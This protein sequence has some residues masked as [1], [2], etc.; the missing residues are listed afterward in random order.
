MKT[1]LKNH[2][3][4]TKQALQLLLRRLNDLAN[5]S[6]TDPI[7]RAEAAYFS[8]TANDKCRDLDLPLQETK[9]LAQRALNVCTTLQDDQLHDYC[10]CNFMTHL[11]FCRE[12]LQDDDVYKIV[13]NAI[14]SFKNYPESAQ[15]VPF[16][17]AKAVALRD[18]FNEN[19]PELV[20]QIVEDVDDLT[21][22]EK[23]RAI[24]QA[25]YAIDKFLKQ[26]SQ[27]FEE[28]LDYQRVCE[29]FDTFTARLYFY[30]YAL[31][32]LLERVR[33]SLTHVQCED[34]LDRAWEGVKTTLKDMDA[35]ASGARD[36][37]DDVDDLDMVIESMILHSPRL[38]T[39][40]SDVLAFVLKHGSYSVFESFWSLARHADSSIDADAVA[41]PWRQLALERLNDHKSPVNTRLDLLTCVVTCDAALWRT[42]QQDVFIAKVFE[43]GA[44]LLED[45]HCNE[46]T[47]LC[48]YAR[49]LELASVSSRDDLAY[50]FAKS[51]LFEL[52]RADSVGMRDFILT[53]SFSH[54]L[55][56][57]ARE[58]VEELLQTLHG[59]QEQI[60]S[61]AQLRVASGEPYEQAMKDAVDALAVEEDVMQARAIVDLVRF[62]TDY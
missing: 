44:A 29:Q 46:S 1:L 61:T 35:L 15:S 53:E 20:D 10:L 38:L 33:E 31:P 18:P 6:A 36:S 58:D 59:K 57:S 26:G 48:G 16:L 43:I 8:L 41:R 23:P 39:D 45:S 51:L 60:V 2:P 9:D 42:T 27:A 7:E 12:S 40:G 24:V 11:L 55:R 14:K 47:A 5:D 56:Y 52:M 22:Y 19:T 32:T 49:L 21:S 25:A 3:T 13:K 30:D 62:L 50:G 34:V 54:L 17:Y 28:L 4:E 37:D